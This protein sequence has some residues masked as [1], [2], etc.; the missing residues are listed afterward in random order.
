MALGL[1]YQG[2]EDGSTSVKVSAAGQADG[3]D[4]I[5]CNEDDLTVLGSGTTLSGDC[6]ITLGTA[7]IV[8]QRIIAFVGEADIAAGREVLES[9]YLSTGWKRPTTITVGETEYTP[10]EYETATGNEVPDVYDP[11][12]VNRVA[13]LNFL[14]SAFTSQTPITFTLTIDR[15]NDA[16]TTVT[17]ADAAGADDFLYK[18]DTDD[19]DNN[20]IKVYDADGTFQVQVIDA[21]D[22]GHYTTKVYAIDVTA[23]APPL[24]EISNASYVQSAGVFPIIDVIADSTPALECKIDGVM[25]SYADMVFTGGKRWKYAGTPLPTT[26][27]YNVRVRVKTDTPDEVQYTA[28]IA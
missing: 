16:Q 26:G 11:L 6:T 13:E 21:A 19:A 5:L 27:T 12:C 22:S 18:F 10:D 20:P 4:I 28:T 14:N 3:T 9:G 17:V 25:G 2:F 24:S 7:L 15:S 1:I 23:P 8:G